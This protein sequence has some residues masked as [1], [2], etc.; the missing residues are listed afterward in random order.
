MGQKFT[1][2]QLVFGSIAFKLFNL[3]KTFCVAF[4]KLPTISWVNFGPFLLTELVQ[5]R[6]VC[7]PPCS[8]TLFQF[9]PQIFCRIEVR[10]LRSGHS[11][12]LTLLSLSHFSTTLEVCLGS[13]SIWKTH[14]RSSF[15]FPTDVL[16]CCFNIST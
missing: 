9:C 5:L 13:L 10:T 1:Y 7:S 2:T 3:S 12:T 14:L 16:R 6:Q 8:H 4:Y 15:N 11:N